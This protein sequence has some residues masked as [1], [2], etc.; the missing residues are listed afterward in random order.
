MIR[1]A[2]Q[3]IVRPS[4]ATTPPDSDQPM[5]STNNQSIRTV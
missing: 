4:G 1:L 3:W 5:I 2:G